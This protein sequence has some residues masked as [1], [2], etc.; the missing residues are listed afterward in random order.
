MPRR[1]GGQRRVGEGEGTGYNVVSNAMNDGDGRDVG[2]EAIWTAHRD[3]FAVG[4]PAAAAVPVSVRVEVAPDEH[5]T[6]RVWVSCP[7]RVVNAA[8]DPLVLQTVEQPRPDNASTAED[9]LDEEFGGFALRRFTHHAGSAPV[10]A[11]PGEGDCWIPPAT[12]LS[13]PPLVTVED[14][15][16]RVQ[17]TEGFGKTKYSYMKASGAES[18][19]THQ[20]HGDSVH[21]PV[22]RRPST[23]TDNRLTLD[24][25]QKA[26]SAA[27]PLRHLLSSPHKLTASQRNLSLLE[28]AGSRPLSPRLDSPASSSNTPPLCL[29]YTSP[30][31]R[32]ATLSRM[33]S[34]A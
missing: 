5:G 27:G 16:G 30:S 29:L 32:D 13:P 28:V 34:S 12:S 11:S 2:V 7:V 3:V 22:P 24:G 19:P 14:S 15:W 9:E 21:S 20:C 31:P 6:R 17:R 10:V 18:D 25:G 8:Q 23:T 26:S 1:R 4:A 33:P